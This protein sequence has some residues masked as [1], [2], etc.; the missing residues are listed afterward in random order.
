MAVMAKHCPNVR[1]MVCDISQRQIDAW[2]S[3]SLPIY[4]PGLE[5][6]IQE[7][8]GRNLWFTTDIKDAIQTCDM[9]FVAVNTP[10]KTSGQVGSPLP[11]HIISRSLSLSLCVRVVRVL[12]WRPLSCLHCL[13]CW[14]SPL[15]PGLS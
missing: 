13:I 4:E 12:R 10:T 11:F 9:I 2:N 15:C 5:Q 8:R 6:V 14:V 7:V 1:F 3:D